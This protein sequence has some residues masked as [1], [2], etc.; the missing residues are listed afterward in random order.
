MTKVKEKT[1]EMKLV[2]FRAVKVL[3]RPVKVKFTMD[4]KE[5]EFDGIEAYEQKIKDKFYDTK[6]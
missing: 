5:V 2:Q 4:G 1:E 3:K 6:R